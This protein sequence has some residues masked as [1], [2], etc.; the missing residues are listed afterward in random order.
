MVPSST[1]NSLKLVDNA[2]WPKIQVNDHLILLLSTV[3][4][5]QVRKLKLISGEHPVA[6]TCLKSITQK[7]Q[8]NFGQKLLHDNFGL[9]ACRFPEFHKKYPTQKNV[10]ASRCC[11]EIIVYQFFWRADNFFRD[12]NCSFHRKKYG[13]K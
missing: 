6:R 7:I 8:K 12:K 5:C 10:A 2:T 11:V 13:M 4:R 9:V 3:K 1:K